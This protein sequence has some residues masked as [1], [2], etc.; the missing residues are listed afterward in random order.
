MNKALLGIVASAFAAGLSFSAPSLTAAASTSTGNGADTSIWRVIPS[1]N[2]Q[3][4]Q[5]TNSSF[6]AISAISASDAWAVGLFMDKNVVGHPLVEHFDG[7]AWSVV[8]APQPAGV[9]ASLAGVDQLSATNTW[10]VGSSGSASVETQQP[11]IEHFDGTSWSIVA[12]AA[13]SAGSTGA[14]DAIGGTGPTDLW[15]VGTQLTAGDA[16]ESVLFEHFDGT[17]WAQVP[18]PT[19]ETACDPGGFD[20]FLGP[21]AVSA[22]APNDVWVAGTIREPNPTGNFLAHFD[23]TS[24]SVV[25]PPCLQGTTI[26]ASCSGASIDQNELTGITVLSSTDAWASGTESNVNNNNF[27]IPYVL[28][29]NGTEWALVTTP[30]QGGEGSR[31]NAITAISP[32]DVWAAGQ[33]QQLNGAITPLTEQFDGTTW[34][35]VPAP[36]PG[37][38]QRL[39]DDP[40]D[41][42]TSPGDH[43]LLA[44]GAR[45]IPGECCLRTFALGTTA[46]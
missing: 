35:R 5:V 23:G 16:G 2:L 11:L 12:G 8:S 31:L 28:H 38:T 40:L 6:A 39:P 19:Q 14:L 29:F 20:C 34:A 43:L 41:G 46:G 26:L 4:N 15:A 33:I 22:D 44:V 1:A 21:Q 13:L 27:N 10:A 45:S 18:F 17:T 36:A 7:S 24:W 3:A 25:H 9:P 37:S 32:S 42:I 30:N